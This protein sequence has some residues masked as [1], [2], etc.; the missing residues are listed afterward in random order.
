MLL[1]A[2]GPVA[3]ARDAHAGAL[4]GCGWGFARVGGANMGSE[5]QPIVA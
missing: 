1:H 3:C 2:A 5:K 4:N